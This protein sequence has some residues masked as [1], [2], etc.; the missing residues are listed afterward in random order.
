ME[1]NKDNKNNKENK[2]DSWLITISFNVI[3]DACPFN[4]SRM[5]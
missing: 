1:N 4:G 2:D 3:S 5:T